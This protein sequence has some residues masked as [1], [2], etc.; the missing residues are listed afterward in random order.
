LL[1]QVPT[2]AWA[3]LVIKADQSLLRSI[4]MR[5]LPSMPGNDPIRPAFVDLGGGWVGFLAAPWHVRMAGL[6]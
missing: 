2:R 3:N 1:D 5:G 4:G 6:I